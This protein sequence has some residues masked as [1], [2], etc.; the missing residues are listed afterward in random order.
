M[1][2]KTKE[3][4]ISKDELR[5]VTS[6]VYYKQIKFVIIVF[7]IITVINIIMAI[8]VPRAANIWLVVGSVIFLSYFLALPY[9]R[10]PAKTQIKLHFQNRTCEIN[11]NYFSTAF[12]DGSLSKIHFNNYIKATRE[13][14]WYFMYLTPAYF[15][16]LPIR[17]FNSEDDINEF[18]AALKT[19]KLID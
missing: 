15:E 17:V 11:D 16:Y 2:I 7:A 13:S 1:N 18:E 4:N 14:D 3:F 19:K 9:I 5:H 12:E 8:L 10:N 6:I